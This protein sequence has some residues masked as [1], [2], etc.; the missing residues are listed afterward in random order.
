M[1][2]RAKKELRPLLL[3]FS[4]SFL[5]RR[6]NCRCLLIALPVLVLVTGVCVSSVMSIISIKG[7][8]R[9]SGNAKVLIS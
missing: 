9:N 5:R 7:L 2:C 8:R 3:E 6:K 1:L 4:E